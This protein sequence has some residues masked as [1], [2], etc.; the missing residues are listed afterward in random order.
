[1]KKN[2]KIYSIWKSNNFWLKWFEADMTDKPN[3]ILNLDRFYYDL[4]VKIG[5]QMH[6]LNLGNDFITSC[7]LETL[8]KKF[9]KDVIFY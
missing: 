2:S 7:L 8:G 3:N 5:D 9:I 1:M 4:L 6:L